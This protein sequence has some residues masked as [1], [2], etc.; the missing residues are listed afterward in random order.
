MKI[1]GKNKKRRKKNIMKRRN[2][3]RNGMFLEKS[4][5]GRVLTQ[6]FLVFSDYMYLGPDVKA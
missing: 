2:Q 3:D 1:D 4:L 5:E 6:P